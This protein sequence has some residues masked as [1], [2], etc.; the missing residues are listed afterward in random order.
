LTSIAEFLNLTCAAWAAP[1]CFSIS[2]GYGQTEFAPPSPSP[3]PTKQLGKPTKLPSNRHWNEDLCSA[4]LIF[5]QHQVDN[6][7]LYMALTAAPRPLARIAPTPSGYLHLG[8]AL[9]FALTWLMVRQAGGQLLLRIDDLDQERARPEYV[10]AIF[11][12]LE[13]LGIDYDLGPSGP[14]EFWQSFSQTKRL[15]LYE[16]QLATLAGATLPDGSPL[17]FACTCSRA[18]VRNS[19]D[20]QYAGTCRGKPVGKSTGA[21]WRVSTPLGSMAAFALFAGGHQQVDVHAQVRDFI[22]RQRGGQPA[23]QVASLTDDLHFGVNLIVRGEDLLAFTGA[24]SYLAAQLPNQPFAKIQFY[25]HPLL[26]GADGQK[27]SKSA[28]AASLQQWWAQSTSAAGFYRSLAK[29]LGVENAAQVTQIQ[30]ILP[31]FELVNLPKGGGSGF[32]SLM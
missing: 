25:H 8:N 2:G 12:D 10:A 31:H 17:V 3:F 7:P 16:A 6:F 30:D 19:P 15:D 5:G 26:A 32:L 9:N 27:L 20:G 11:R 21:T 4:L 14:D 29:L 13:W 23:Y 22:V 28:G 24:Q 18:Q 1:I